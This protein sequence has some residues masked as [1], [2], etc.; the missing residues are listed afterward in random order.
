MPCRTATGHDLD[1]PF[2]E[3]LDVLGVV[4]DHFSDSSNLL[5]DIA[6]V[7]LLSDIYQFGIHLVDPGI[8]L[9][10]HRIDPGDQVFSLH[11]QD[12]FW[13]LCSCAFH[14]RDCGGFSLQS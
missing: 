10:V 8:D 11:S 13:S 7:K 4:Q 3:V 14:R 12:Q 1:L 9:P 2:L 6:A 5:G